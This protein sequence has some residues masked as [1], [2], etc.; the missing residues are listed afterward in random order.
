MYPHLS[1]ARDELVQAMRA[2]YD[3]IIDFVTTPEF[4]AIMEEL[5]S[6]QGRDRPAFVA[7]V[8]VNKEELARRGVTI[9]EGILIQRSAFGDRRPT[10]FCVKKYLP[11]RFHDV[12]QNVNIT[13]DNEFA[14]ASVSRA[15]EVAW[16]HP[17]PVPLQSEIM[18]AGGNLEQA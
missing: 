2:T 6:L 14:D 7:S 10:L 16:R 18:A 17:L 5:G 8:L 13:F 3:E 15:P 9:P 1:Y 11:D 4:K 12:W